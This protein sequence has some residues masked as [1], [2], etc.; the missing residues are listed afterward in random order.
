MAPRDNGGACTGEPPPPYLSFHSLT[1]LP[2]TH[3]LLGA[4]TTSTEQGHTRRM[5]MEAQAIFG[6]GMSFYILFFS[7]HSFPTSS[8]QMTEPGTRMG[9]HTRG[10]GRGAHV[11][12]MGASDEQPWRR[13]CRLRHRL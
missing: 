2:C 7:Y 6:V 9:E 5:Q 13:T 8:L 4:N 12:N 11:T 10:R 1:T 3:T